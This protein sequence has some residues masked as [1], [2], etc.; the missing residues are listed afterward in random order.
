MINVIGI[1]LNDEYK[2]LREAGLGEFVDMLERIDLARS[3]AHFTYKDPL[4]QKN[5]RDRYK[6]HETTNETGGYPPQIQCCCA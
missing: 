6:H 2:Q 1:M 5:Q 3:Y 4:R